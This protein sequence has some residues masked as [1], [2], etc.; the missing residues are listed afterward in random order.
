MKERMIKLFLCVGLSVLSVYCGGP[1]LKDKKAAF[2][3]SSFRVYLLGAQ[4]AEYYAGYRP[5]NAENDF[6]VFSLGFENSTDQPVVV[7][8]TLVFLENDKGKFIGVPVAFN[9]ATSFWASFKSDFRRSF[10]V[11]DK[12]KATVEPG[13]SIAKE[14]GFL[15]KRADLPSQ[16]VLLRDPGDELAKSKDVEKDRKKFILGKVKL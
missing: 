6:Y 4:R 9:E 1:Q 7:D 3:T 10:G 12:I 5:K 15:L 2:D 8:W 14:Y 13:E 16:L 11:A